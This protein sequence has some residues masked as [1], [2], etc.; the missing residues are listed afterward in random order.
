MADIKEAA[1]IKNIKL[2]NI[3]P[4]PHNPRRVFDKEPLEVLQASIKR[5]GVLVPITV[6]SRQIKT[7]KSGKALSP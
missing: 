4:N 2:E 1:K 7:S 3:A 6:Y 5:L